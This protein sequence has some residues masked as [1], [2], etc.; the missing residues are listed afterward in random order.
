MP[1]L[2][3]VTL[4]AATAALDAAS[5]RQQVIATNIA[6]AG[7]ADYAAQRVRFS[8]ELARAG[9]PGRSASA[10]SSRPTMPAATLHT[11]V[12]TLRDLDGQPRPVQLDAEVAALGQ[13]TTHYQALLR[14]LGQHYALLASAVSEGKR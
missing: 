5:L 10:M 13:N 14:A 2:E 11:Q 8:A 1:A 6:N 3:P 7:R 12:E 4:A 9:D